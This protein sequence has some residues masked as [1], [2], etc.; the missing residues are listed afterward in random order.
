MTASPP[1]PLATPRSMAATGAARPDSSMTAGIAIAALPLM[2]LAAPCSLAG[3]RRAAL[4]DPAGSTSASIEE[5]LHRAAAANCD[6]RLTSGSILADAGR[7]LEVDGDGRV[8]KPDVSGTS[9]ITMAALPPMPLA[10]PKLTAAT[11]A[12]RPDSSTVKEF[13]NE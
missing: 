5:V 2:P 13:K 9:R 6:S 7:T 11:G 8:A 3:S 1:M 4:H 12:A 10:T